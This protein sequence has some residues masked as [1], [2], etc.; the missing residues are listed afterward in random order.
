[1]LN[2]VF[3]THNFLVSHKHINLR[4]SPLRG[5]KN[6]YPSVYRDS[7]LGDNKNSNFLKTSIS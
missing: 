4:K 7:K 1:M 5:T 6:I 3:L 2:L